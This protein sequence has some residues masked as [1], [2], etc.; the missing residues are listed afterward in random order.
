MNHL[1]EE[2]FLPGQPEP[3]VEKLLSE[4]KENRTNTSFGHIHKPLSSYSLEDIRNA[5]RNSEW[6]LQSQTKSTRAETI[7][8]PDP[9]TFFQLRVIRPAT[10]SPKGI[11]LHF[12]SG[13]FVFGSNDQDDIELEELADKTGRI[14]VSVGFR[15]APEYPWPAC[16]IDCELATLWV[17]NNCERL[18]HTDNIV[19]GGEFTGGWLSLVTLLRMKA[20]GYHQAISGITLVSGIFDLTLTPSAQNKPDCAFL[21]TQDII[22][23]IRQLLQRTEQTQSPVLSPLYADLALLPPAFLISGTDD[24]LLDDTMFLHCRLLASGNESKLH[25]AQNG[26]HGFTRLPSK[27]GESARQNLH[28]FLISTL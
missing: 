5:R 20:R 8:I 21:G 26:F 25:I 6:I 22:F 2:P 3:S 4:I 23:C 19:L 27:I 16:V 14:A 1:P 11:Y 13:G 18:W 9:E 17:I 10:G 24:A 7:A 15:L 12:H 28:N